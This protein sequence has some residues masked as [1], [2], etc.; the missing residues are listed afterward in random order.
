MNLRIHFGRRVKKYW[1]CHSKLDKSIEKPCFIHVFTWYLLSFVGHIAF[2]KMNG[3]SCQLSTADAKQRKTMRS[4]E[5]KKF[6][7]AQEEFRTFIF[8]FVFI[9]FFHYNFQILIKFGELFFF[10]IYTSTLCIQENGSS[11]SYQKGTKIWRLIY[12]I[13]SFLLLLTMQYWCGNWKKWQHLGMPYIYYIT[14]GHILN[15][16]PTFADMW[17]AW[18]RT[19]RRGKNVR[20]KMVSKANVSFEMFVG[21]KFCCLSSK[22]FDT[23]FSPLWHI[24][25]FSR[26]LLLF[27]LVFIFVYISTSSAIQ[28]DLNSYS[29]DWCSF[30]S[31]ISLFFD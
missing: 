10:F 18:R 7:T 29:V 15:W 8:F 19:R 5:M 21:V 31:S 4:K 3:S 28:K 12:F 6:Q 2:A 16:F 17:S 20:R 11:D 23:Y 22:L 13:K 1:N 27:F 25:F 26:S 9:F 14:C 30:S 24:F